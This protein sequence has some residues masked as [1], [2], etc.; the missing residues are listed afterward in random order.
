[1]CV[2]QLRRN[3]RLFFMSLLPIVL[4]LLSGFQN[5]LALNKKESIKYFLE[6]FESSR[7]TYLPANKTKVRTLIQEKL[8]EQ[9]FKTSFQAVPVGQ[10]SYNVIGRIDGSF[11]NTAEDRIFI[12]GAH[13]DTYQDSPGVDDN[14]SGLAA[15][16]QVARQFNDPDQDCQRNYT[17]ILVAF[18]Q[19][20][21]QSCN[22]EDRFQ[23]ICSYGSATFIKDLTGYLGVSN[24]K[25]KIEGAVILDGIMNFDS[26]YDSQNFTELENHVDD[27]VRSTVSEIQR[28]NN[29]GDFLLAV[30]RTVKEDYLFDNI[31]KYF[32][33]S[34]YHRGEF[35]LRNFKLAF[36]QRPSTLNSVARDNYRYFFDSDHYSFW[37]ND[38]PI[39][40]L[41]LTDTLD[42]RGYMKY[43]YHNECDN[44]SH[45]TSDRLHFL[46]NTADAVAMTALED[47][48]LVE[49]IPRTFG[50]VSEVYTSDSGE[51]QSPGY[52]TKYPNKADSIWTITVSSGHVVDLWFTEFDLEANECKSDFVDV[53]NDYDATSL[54]GRYC[55][56]IAA[57]KIHLKSKGRTMQIRF[58]SDDFITSKG[59]KA[60]WK[61]SKGSSLIGSSLLSYLCLAL[62]FLWKRT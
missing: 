13:Y 12:V 42:F 35:K 20:E 45:A 44:L 52:P 61:A 33:E 58:R 17:L 7:S 6:H 29:R 57:S 30:G 31:T 4:I 39:K 37:N 21:C 27:S 46:T 15:L 53:W 36:Q 56:K 54:I 23:C 48:G 25:G 49:C 18:D 40:A 3:F 16:L 1:M 43:C 62:I 55:G 32:R 5:V 60:K 38:P 59:F 26:S 50:N 14:G 9:G 2:R 28:N 19:K 10:D 24:E 22:N 11:V 51:F 34:Q 47:T 8:K 41:Y